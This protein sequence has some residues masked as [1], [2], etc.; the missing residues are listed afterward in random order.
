MMYI[1]YMIIN[2]VNGKT[3][4]GQH[5]SNSWQDKYMGSGHYLARAKKK[6]GIEKYQKQEKANIGNLLTENE[7]GIR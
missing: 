4:I 6:Y 3:Y 5:K 7:F 2:K 1:I